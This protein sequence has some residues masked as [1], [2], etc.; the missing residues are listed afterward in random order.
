MNFQFKPPADAG[1]APAN[2]DFAEESPGRSER[3]IE[4]EEREREQEESLEGS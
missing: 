1:L 4:E 3:E 2:D